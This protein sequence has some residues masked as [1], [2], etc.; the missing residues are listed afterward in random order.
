VKVDDLLRFLGLNYVFL[1]LVICRIPCVASY[2]SCLSQFLPFS[3]P[4][5]YERALE[6]G[7]S[8]DGRVPCLISIKSQEYCEK[9]LTYVANAEWP[10]KRS[11]D[12]DKSPCTTS[13]DIS[14]ACPVFQTH[15]NTTLVISSATFERI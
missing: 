2:L 14:S 13:N 10:K 3:S 1:L 15:C 6:L 7:T 8:I 11:I 4:S 12:Y 5:V 9:R